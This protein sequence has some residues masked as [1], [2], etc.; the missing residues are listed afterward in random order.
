[1]FDSI[2]MDIAKIGP[3]FGLLIIAVWALFQWDKANRAAASAREI[4]GTKANSDLQQ[5]VY[6]VQANIIEVLQNVVNN[7]TAAFNHNT[8]LLARVEAKLNEKSSP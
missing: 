4:A 7:N 1:M 2:V 6:E 5:K 8:A 3:A